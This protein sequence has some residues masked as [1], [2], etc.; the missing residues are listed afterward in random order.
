MSGLL[1]LPQSRKKNVVNVK[2]TTSE[3]AMM[4]IN[5]DA[6]EAESIRPE[7]AAG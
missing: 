6:F 2:S 7:S 4:N 5:D 3:R 1:P